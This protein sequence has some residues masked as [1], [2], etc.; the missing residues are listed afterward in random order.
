MCLVR[1][2]DTSQSEGKTIAIVV[3]DATTR[4]TFLQARPRTV[5][6]RNANSFVSLFKPTYRP[7]IAEA[8]TK[9]QSDGRIPK[10]FP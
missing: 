10:S 8:F 4:R 2:K 5:Q 3:R 1:G 6:G 9:D 7:G